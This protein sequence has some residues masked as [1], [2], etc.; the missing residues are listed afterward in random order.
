MK[1]AFATKNA[2]KLR[3][4]KRVMKGIRA[5]FIPLSDFAGAPN[6]RESGKTFEENAL[7]KAKA[8]AKFT[9]LPALADDSGLCVDF[10]HGAPGI[11]SARFEKDD[12]SRNSKLLKLLDGVLP[13]G[14]KA[15]FVCVAALAFPDGRAVAV[16]GEA[17]GTIA[18]EE[19]GRAGF[20]YDP[21]FI[22]AGYART[23]AELGRVVK[24]RIS[25]RARA[26]AKMK[27]R[28]KKITSA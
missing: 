24:N 26:F 3:E 5:Q 25:H 8:I 14:R 1:I 27:P 22:P 19:R 16:R 18:T 9:G 10:L 15:V 2:E 20:G 17:K 6:V 4:I 12:A 23:Y 28:V 11:R 13:K 7:V 21:I